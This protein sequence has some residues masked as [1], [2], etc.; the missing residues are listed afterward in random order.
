[1]NQSTRLPV[2][3]G[4]LAAT[5]GML[6]A[7]APALGADDA[8]IAAAKKE[9]EVT[10]YTTQIITQIGRPAM[11]AFQKKYGIKVNAI[12]GDSVELS[13][14]LLNEAKAGRTQADVF[15]GTSTATA[16]KKGGVALKWQPDRT[17]ELPP[18]YWDAE[19]Y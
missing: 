19:G 11:E 16:L 12:R 18:E 5:L 8:L 14:R 1:M 3:L 2:T 6:A 17:R 15:D 10:W 4:V 13:V 7:S 9:G